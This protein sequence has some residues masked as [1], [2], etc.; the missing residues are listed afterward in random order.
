MSDKERL[1]M[2][3]NPERYIGSV[4][5]IKGQERLRSGAIRHPVFLRL[6][7]HK[8]PKDCIWYKNEQ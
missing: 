3:L 8:H 2:S 6:N 5:T 4:V 1:D 7:D